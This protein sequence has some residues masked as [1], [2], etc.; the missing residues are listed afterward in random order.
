MV[1]SVTRTS[2]KITDT[3]IKDSHD[4]ILDFIKGT[5]RKHCSVMATG[6]RGSKRA[7]SCARHPLPGTILSAERGYDDDKLLLESLP[8]W[9]Y[10]HMKDSKIAQG[11][12]LSDQTVS[13]SSKGKKA[14]PI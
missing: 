4:F 3:C 8:L 6:V 7:L 5:L 9:I 12:Y 13:P 14:S 2:D 10:S 1:H 11:Q